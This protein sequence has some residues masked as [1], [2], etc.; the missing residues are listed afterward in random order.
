MN[1]FSHNYQP[2]QAVSEYQASLRAQKEH[3]KHVKA[4]T[5]EGKVYGYEL[6][7]RTPDWNQLRNLGAG[8]YGLN[9][10]ATPQLEEA[11][12]QLHNP[13]LFDA[14][15]DNRYYHFTRAEQIERVHSELVSRIN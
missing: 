2:N 9:M 1:P 4:N 11:L 12:V 10:Y 3:D 8:Q 13:D 14:S 5:P 15:A 6:Q 7:P